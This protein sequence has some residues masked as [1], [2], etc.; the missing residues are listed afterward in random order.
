MQ[1]IF[2]SYTYAPHPDHAETLEH[3]ER[4]VRRVIEAMDLRVVDGRNLGGRA[5][6]ATIQQRIKDADALIAL[7]TPQADAAGKEVL[8]Q[9]VVSEFQHAR[10][11]GK[12]TLRIEHEALEVRG[13]GANDEYVPYRAG[14]LLEVIMTVLQ[15]LALWKEEH[16]RPVQ[17]RIEP[18][19]LAHRYDEARMDRCEYELL[20]EG[21]AKATAPVP[22]SLVPEPGAAYVHVPNFVEGMRVRVK[23][24]VGGDQW[25]STFVQ[26]HMAG[27]AVTKIGV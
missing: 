18:V 11:I 10:A 5:L 6:E 17:I 24:T 3:L 2:L 22:A 4:K 12:P 20:R 19:E 13:L 7:Y 27:V 26:P 25:R 9:Y 14:D 15:K 1:R 21:E 23:L 16:G 8:P